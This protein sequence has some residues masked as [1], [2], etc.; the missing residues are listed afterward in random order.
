MAD[1]GFGNP[2]IIEEEV[3]ILLIGGGMACCGAAFEIMRWAEGT[4]LKIKLVDKAAMDRSGAVAQG[5]SAINTY[6]GDNDPSDYVRYVRND[7]MGIVREDL[8]YDVGRHVDDSVHNFEQW[9]LPI[10]KQPGDEDKTLRDGGKP[11]RSGKWQIMING[12]SYKWIVAEAAKK[13]LGI[14]NI[15]ERVFIVRMVNDKNDPTRVAGAAGFSVR[16]HKLYI[17]KFKC[18]L[19][20][21]GGAVNVFRPRSI[22]EGMGRAWYPVWN[23]GSTYAMAAESGAAMTMMENRFVPARF[24]DGYGPVGAWFLLFKAQVMNGA[25]EDYNKINGHIIKDEQ[26]FGK[27]GQGVPGTCLRNHIMLQEMK[28]GRGP[29]IMD[30]PGAMARLAEK[31]TPKEV[32][33]LEAEAWEDFLDMTIAQ[34]GIWAGENIEPDKQPSEIMPT[35]PYLL[36]SHSGCAGI[37]VSGPTDIPGVPKE[38][39]WGY[40]RMTTVKGLFTAGDGVGASGHK[41]SSGSH[42]EGRIAAKAMVKFALDNKDWKPELA[43]S[44]ADLV[45]EIYRPVKTFLEHKDYTTAIDINPHYITPKMLQ[46]RLQKIMDEY[47]AGVSTWYQTNAKM[48]EICES[49]LEMVKEDSLKMR[50]KDLHELL[51]AWENYH[52]IIAAECHMKHIQFREETRYPGFYYRSDYNFIDDTNWKCFTNSQYDRETKKWKLWKEPY[53]QLIKD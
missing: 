11:V 47:C 4:G 10:W 7:L 17:Y 14:E 41:F 39:S 34:C 29:I 5:L 6:M 33:H 1:Y 49:K 38:W 18:C 2:E 30:T 37:W 8:I 45:E 28:E 21:A 13:A 25:G 46:F 42:A 24:K 40:N 23:A 19:L 35:E 15:Q 52:R 53:V 20:A 16:D 36:G 50:A 51:R 43:R 48:L 12:E 22:G 3:D 26:R 9:G 32:K 31:M 27:Y 44:V